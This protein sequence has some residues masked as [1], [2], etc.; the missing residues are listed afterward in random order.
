MGRLRA[1]AARIDRESVWPKL[2]QDQRSRLAASVWE[3]QQGAA[4]KV[5][6][7][8]ELRDVWN[9]RYFLTRLTDDRIRIL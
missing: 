4:L 6:V 1:F 5:Q 3:G 8:Q 9:P 7:E 2:V